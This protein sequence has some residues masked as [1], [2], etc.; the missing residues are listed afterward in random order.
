MTGK[1]ELCI[2]DILSAV[3]Y[4]DIDIREE[5]AALLLTYYQFLRQENSK[6]TR[7]NK[8]SRIIFGA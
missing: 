3:A 1:N 5:Q 2:G 4:W 7:N 6:D 8:M